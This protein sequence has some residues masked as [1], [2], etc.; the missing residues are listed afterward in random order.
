[1]STL[2]DYKPIIIKQRWGDNITKCITTLST[3]AQCET[4][5]GMIKTSI[6]SSQL[7]HLLI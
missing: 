6:P 5:D 7:V 2:T 4:M 1:M 3:E